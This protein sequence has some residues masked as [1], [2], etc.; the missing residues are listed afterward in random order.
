MVGEKIREA[1]QQRGWSQ[2]FLA[3]KLGVTS[4]AIVYWETGRS[5]PRAHRMREVA[6]LLGLQLED[7]IPEAG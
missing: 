6:M 7:L 1:R 5:V 3:E 4:V 2:R